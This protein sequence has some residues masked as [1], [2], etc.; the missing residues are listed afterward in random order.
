MASLEGASCGGVVDSVVLLGLGLLLLWVGASREGGIQRPEWIL[1][2]LVLE[3]ILLLLIVVKG[4]IVR[5]I[6]VMSISHYAA[7]SRKDTACPSRV[8]LGASCYLVTEHSWRT[9]D[10]DSRRVCDVAV[11]CE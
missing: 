3:C 8:D 10:I 7:S 9:S 6:R 11:R 2:L 1:L 4:L 5:C